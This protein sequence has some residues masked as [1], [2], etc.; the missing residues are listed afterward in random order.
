MN[1]DIVINRKKLIPL[2]IKIFGWIFIVMGVSIILIPFITPFFSIPVTYELF[3][4]SS[5]GSPFA[6][7]ALLISAII[8]SHSISAYGLLFGRD[9][10]LIACLITGHIAIAICIFSMLTSVTSGAVN[11]RLELILLIPYVLKLR[12][13][14][15]QWRQAQI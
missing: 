1:S 12:K 11:L 10:G 3:G 6:P 15:K 9:W 14:K 8:L 4:L 13:I 7:M 5:Q 2:W